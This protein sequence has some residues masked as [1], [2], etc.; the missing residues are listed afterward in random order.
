MEHTDKVA[1]K[2]DDLSGLKRPELTRLAK[3]LGINDLKGKNETLI[4][5][6]IT[7][8]ETTRCEYDDMGELQAI[9][10]AEERVK[11][12]PVLG[13]YVKAVITPRD[14]EVKRE[15]FANN[16]YQ[17]NAPMNQ[18]IVIPVEFIKFINTSCYELEHHYDEHKMNPETGMR[19][20]DTTRRVQNYFC[21][22]V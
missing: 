10:T 6:M 15:F 2:L 7:T 13:E 20:V 12:H 3:K 21:S 9:Q 11:R 8:S 4:E 22:Q 1:Y 16:D 5:R 14:S 17:C 19:G 18:E